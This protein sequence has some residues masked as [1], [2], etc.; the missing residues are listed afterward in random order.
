[1][2]HGKSAFINSLICPA[3]GDIPDSIEQELVE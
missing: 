2:G 1:M 3:E